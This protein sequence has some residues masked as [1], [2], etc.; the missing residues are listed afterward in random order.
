MVCYYG[1]MKVSIDRA[2]RIVIPKSVRREMHLEPG[3]TLELE[4]QGDGVALR[5]ARKS[6]SF[7]MV[8][9]VWLV[10]TGVPLSE[11]DVQEAAEQARLKRED[12]IAGER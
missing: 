4:L 11:A 2:G 7:R 12:R 6:A 9:G 8:D 3:D 1:I 10:R 5:P